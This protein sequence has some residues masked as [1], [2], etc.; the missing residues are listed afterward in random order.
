[1]LERV[2][3]EPLEAVAVGRVVRAQ[4][5]LEVLVGDQVQQVADALGVRA[6]PQRLLD[7][8]AV[9]DVVADLVEHQAL[10]DVLAV[11]LVAQHRQRRDED[12]RR[13]E[14]RVA[15]VGL[16]ARQVKAEQPPGQLDALAHAP[17]EHLGD[18]L[19]PPRHERRADRAGR[20]IA[21]RAADCAQLEHAHVRVAELVGWTGRAS[22][23]PCSTADEPLLDARRH[24]RR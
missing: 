21:A 10:D 14:P 20:G 24:R 13:V 2:G 15:E 8:A 19:E 3:A 23:A 18:A 17:R 5:A 16:L 22:I 9:I 12:S 6:L 11:R 7:L 1:M 4:V